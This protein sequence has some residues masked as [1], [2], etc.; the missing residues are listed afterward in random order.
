M[1]FIDSCGAS[2]IR[3]KFI[4]QLKYTVKNSFFYR[5]KY[6][7]AGVDIHNIDKIEITSLPFTEKIELLEDQKEYP[8]YGNNLCVDLAKVQR[9]HRTSGTTNKHLIVALTKNDINAIITA[10]S[11]CYKT[12]GLSN[13]HTVIHCLNYNMWM[14]GLTDHQNLEA[15]GATVIPFGVGNSKSLIDY[16]IALNVDVISSTPSYLDKLEQ[17][18]KAEFNIRPIDLNL[19]L[20]LLGTESGL[21]DLNYRKKLERI[22]G[23]SAVNANFGIAEVLSILGSEC[24]EKNGLH[25]ISEGK[26]YVEVIDPE[27]QKLLPIERGTEGELV[28]TNLDKEAQPL[29]RY[30]TRDMIK[31]IDI[32]KC[33][34]GLESFK[35]NII[36]RSDDM[37]V[38]KGLNIFPSQ[39]KTLISRYLDILT[40]QFIIILNTP[41]PIE[42]LYIKVEYLEKSS[43]P[44]IAEV[45]NKLK[46]Q[47]KENFFITPIIEMVNEG[48]IQRT[49]GKSRYIKKSY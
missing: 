9:I 21:Q 36:G 25:F 16:I 24:K 22:W 10:G 17:L 40:G 34:C 15:T 26:L 12:A 47:I 39:I 20:G 43:L 19:K 14:G 23:I 4:K 3:T 8:P 45:K 28:L 18:L 49:D 41:P 6:E 7:K 44:E 27:T 30:R 37:L 31:I 35:F 11:K 33:S 1:H 46:K 32:G 2:N 38:I 5:R 13:K 42:S 29:I 48:T